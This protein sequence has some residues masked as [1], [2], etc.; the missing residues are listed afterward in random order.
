MLQMVHGIAE[1]RELSIKKN[2]QLNE[3]TVRVKLGKKGDC[4][5]THHQRVQR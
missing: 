2:Q 5:T 4:L 3:R 1:E